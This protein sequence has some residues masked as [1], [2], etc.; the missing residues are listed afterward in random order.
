MCNWLIPE[1]RKKV[2]I[3]YEYLLA[4]YDKN[5]CKLHIVMTLHKGKIRLLCHAFENMVYP[6]QTTSPP[7]EA[8]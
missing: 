6:E 2:M 1:Y 5:P 3:P 4:K 7:A 8:L